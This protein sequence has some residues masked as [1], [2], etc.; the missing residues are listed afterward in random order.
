MIVCRSGISGFFRT[1]TKSHLGIALTSHA[2]DRIIRRG[3]T[4]KAAALLLFRYIP[5]HTVAI[6]SVFRIY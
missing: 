5:Y 2:R 3:D 4:T 6:F 1:L